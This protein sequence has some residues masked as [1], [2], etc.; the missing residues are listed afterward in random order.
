M[1]G[2]A[3]TWHREGGAGEPVVVLPGGPCRGVEYLE[4]LAGLADDRPLVVMTRPGR[5]A[6]HVLR[7]VRPRSRAAG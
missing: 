2:A 7:E 3:L 6:R 5:G 4:D 1:D